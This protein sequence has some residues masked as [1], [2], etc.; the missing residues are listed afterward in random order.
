MHEKKIEAINFQMS[1]AD[2]ERLHVTE[3]HELDM[4]IKREQLK[5]E[6]IKTRI[7]LFDLKLKKKQY[8]AIN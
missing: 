5:Q 1:V 6:K 4:E 2:K 7:L 3:A 8:L